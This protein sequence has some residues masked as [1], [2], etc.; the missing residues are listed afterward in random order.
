MSMN[1]SARKVYADQVEDIIDKLG[2]QQTVEL[3]SDICYEKA[4]HI[5]ENW[6]DENTAHAWDFAGG[7]LFKAC[8]STAIKSL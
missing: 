1:D 8:L 3:I 4:N 5:Q 2:L 6:Q 7:Y